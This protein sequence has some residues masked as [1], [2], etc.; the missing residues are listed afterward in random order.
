MPRKK[1]CLTPRQ[2]TRSLPLLTPW[3]HGHS[4]WQPTGSVSM[5]RLLAGLLA[6]SSPRCATKGTAGLDPLCQDTLAVAPAGAKA[7]HVAPGTREVGPQ[8][9][10]QQHQGSGDLRGDGH[11]AMGSC[12]TK[13]PGPHIFTRGGCT[14]GT[15]STVQFRPVPQCSSASGVVGSWHP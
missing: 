5:A 10:Q 15:C 12:C 3:H 14:E 6:N 13:P 11:S 1:P 4:R 9:Q 8:Q 7:S 2:V